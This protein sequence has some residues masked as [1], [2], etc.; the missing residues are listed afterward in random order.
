MK[1]YRFP[2]FNLILLLFTGLS[3]FQ[4]EKETGNIRPDPA[5]TEYISAYTSGIISNRTTIKFHL[6]KP[7]AKAEPGQIIKEEIFSFKPKIEGK[8]YWT[9]NRTIEFRP[10]HLLNPDTRYKGQFHLSAI[11]ET[12]KKLSIF[13]FQFRT[14]PQTVEV[15]FLGISPL[16]ENNMK[17]QIVEGN[18]ITSDFS[19]AEAIEHFASAFQGKK[20]L[21]ISWQHSPDGKVHQFK[22]DSVQRTDKAQKISLLWNGMEIGAQKKGEATF[23][24]PS[25]SD[26]KV[27]DIKIRQQPEQLIEIYFSDPI[28][29]N[30]DLEGLIYFTSGV[31]IRLIRESNKIK[32]YPVKPL[33]GTDELIINTGIKNIMGYH[34]KEIFKRNIEFTSQKPAVEAVGNG[35]IM[36]A[37]KGLIFPF[38]AVN[39]KAVNVKIIKIF[40]DNILQ[41][42]QTNQLSGA[43]EL[44][45]VGRIVYKDEITLKTNH[46][47]NYD[48]WNTFSI[49]LSKLIKVDPGS[50]YR[51]LISFNR[52]QSLFPCNNDSENNISNSYDKEIDESFDDPA[53]WYNDFKI[54][55]RNYNYKDRDNPC[56]PTY[57]MQE[58]RF[59]ARN[60]LASDLGIIAKEGVG[61][62]MLI[63]ITDLKTTK[64]IPGTTVEI[65][66][67]QHRLIGKKKS[68]QQ[69]FI[70]L[71]LDN[72]PFLLI[73]KNEA[74]RGYLRLD[75]GS[76]LSLSMFD[77]GG[78]KSK[79]GI[80]GFLYGERGVWRPGDSIYLSFI[81]EDKNRLLPKEHPVVFELYTPHNRLYKRIV[82]HQ[83]VNHFYNFKTSTNTDDPTG[84]WKAKVK[85]GNSVFQKTIRIETVKPNRLKISLDFHKPY[86][87]NNTKNTGDLQV[88]WLHGAIAGNL[89][90]DIE[91]SL[92]PA[93]TAFKQY[94][95]F[96]FD[97]P[98]KEFYSEQKII[99]KGKVDA[100]G[101]AKIDPKIMVRDNAPGM[102]HAFFKIRAFEKGGE[103]SVDRSSI[104]FSPYRGYVGIKVPEGKGW[105]G[106]LYSN[107]PNMISI[108]T[109]DEN[110]KPVNRKGLKIE[111]YDVYWRWWWERSD[112]D[113]LSRYVA[114]RSKN[115][116]KTATIDTKNGKALY[117]LNFDKDLYGRKFIRV[118]D[119]KT[120]HSS[121]QTFYVTYKGWWNNDQGE[122][123]GGA[124]MLTFTTGKKI[125]K[126]GEKIRVN[127][128]D[129][130]E[131]KILASIETGSKILNAFWVDLSKKQKYFEIEATPEMSP[132][133]YINL[134]LIQPYS[135]TTNDRPIRL[136]GVQPVQIENKNS[137]LEPV[138]TMPSE[139]K[140][141]KEFKV[142]ISEKQ[143]KE[144]TYTLAVVDEGLLDLTRFKTPDPWS[145]FNAKEALSVHTWDM[146]QYVMGAFTGKMSGLLALGG[147]EYLKNN[148]GNKANRFKPV[149]KFL[150][151]FELPAH[152][153]KTH[154]I[155]MPNYIGSVKTMVVAGNQ[156]AYGSTEK[157]TPVKKP[158]MVLATLP[159]VV[160]P[161]EVVS[162]PVTVFAMDKKI[163][164]VAVNIIPNSLLTPQ[165]ESKKNIL[166]KRDGDHVINFTLKVAEKLGVAKISIIAT[167]G[168]EKATYD[169]ELDVR[170]P[171]PKITDVK[172]AVIEPGKSLRSAYKALGISGTNKGVVEISSTPPLKLEE[173]LDYLIDYPHG[174]IEQTTSSVFPQLY[175]DNLI[176][177]KSEEKQK[178]EK[179]IKA[180]INKIRSF[181]IVSGGFSYWPGEQSASDW[182]TSY[183]GH[184]LLEAKAKGYSLPSGL[185]IQWINF[186][187]QRANTWTNDM[188][189]NGSHST[190]Q[191]IQA[192]RLYTL[193]LAKSP[194]LGA[195]NRLR[196]L[197]D[198]APGAK[199]RL[200][201]TYYL[202]GKKRIA[203]KII[204]K[205]ST[206]PE[207]YK[208]MSG[209]FGS[210]V[211]DKAMILETLIAFQDKEQ[212]KAVFD[213]IA[214]EL[215]SENWYSTQTTAY[216]LLAISKFIGNT[217][218]SDKHLSFYFSINGKNKKVD[219]EKPVYI[220]DLNLNKENS[221]SVE[222][223]NSGNKTLFMKIQL[224]GIPHTGDPSNAERNLKMQVRY[225]SLSGDEI[226]PASLNQGTDF[227]AEVQLTHPGIKG[228]YKEMALTQIFPS[229]WEIRNTRLDDVIPA[230]SA[231][232][233]RYQDIRDDRVLTYFNLE[234]G[235]SKTFRILLNAS[236]LG[237]YYL[238]TVYCQAMY[239]ND[240]YARKAGKWVK[241]TEPGKN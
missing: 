100:G 198:L 112:E 94:Q 150:G 200:A 140:P 128:P 74:Q 47:L 119:P 92:T 40:E 189:N 207:S 89:K 59:I 75:D 36:P 116:I 138:I 34:L 6:A 134:T 142:K 126:T 237:K 157:I 82:T 236:Y 130:S 56:K 185:L 209:S 152:S 219:Q 196:S 148:E 17:W 98:S 162:L 173:R 44:N 186:Q 222:I 163:K 125:Y 106:A 48:R 50:I 46:T 13:P 103:F 53:G 15:E 230:K 124:E 64:P 80:K 81:L 203:Q 159:R 95:G 170:A 29:K 1:P 67:F 45:R 127:L 3:F 141:K 54:N 214:G 225:L 27:I 4:C 213:E 111:I 194:V 83:S 99:F 147:D 71:D 18:L 96:V 139:L 35:M 69:G 76:A 62:K 169:I 191:L 178:I 79:K 136:Y 121:G 202:I 154:T 49:D 183:A 11:T 241:V 156:T 227:I 208:E 195:M 190:S 192:Y 158:L 239:N 167:G 37:S 5:F 149:V 205:L 114:N 118:I 108:V 145:Y 228:D 9:D 199:W 77:V 8:T 175:L 174:C 193:A 72:K 168:I 204:A 188:N 233:P 120:G 146:Y 63:A 211:R 151:P 226:D 113:N 172:S 42:L 87:S 21:D 232:K 137:H 41:F 2:L 238:P 123:P 182:G 177:L 32:V 93:K 16:N 166:F 14:I 240:I 144:M 221:G 107:E 235:K 86:L 58:Q 101:H 88:K 30:M 234:R 85:I 171:N 179:N 104:L 224:E 65:Y 215:A 131:G 12:P 210:D 160:S 57:Y 55:Y 218:G 165:G 176:R 229:G 26:F 223:K 187:K 135:K 143:G 153:S 19:E 155:V 78:Q 52:S 220:A 66:N 216:A 22:I 24:I 129:A 68:D 33:K 7:L 122:N 73:A 133:I 184:F 110:G 61:N 23:D 31:K 90:A 102:L 25:L 161:G 38:R 60:I 180:G 70:K 206:N 132:N 109:V 117:E 43:K 105:N 20:V 217:G 231:Q 201:L 97:D 115:L 39:L 181:Q 91:L 164:N 197:N 10:D 212:A 51:V 84:F 28:D